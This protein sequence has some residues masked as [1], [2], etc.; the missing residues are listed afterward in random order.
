[1]RD[2]VWCQCH[3]LPGRP[4]RA[5]THAVS[6]HPHDLN[7]L[8]AVYREVDA[9]L[10]GW[11]CE[12]STDCCHFGRTGRE[13][14]LWPN[15]WA[16]LERALRARPVARTRRLPVVDEGRC[17]LLDDRGR[18]AAY[19]ERPFG[20]RTYFCA[21]AVGPARRPPRVELGALARRV[22]ALAE[23]ADPLARPRSLTRWLDGRKY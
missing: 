11:S 7:A 3:D 15:E 8:A 18:C 21:R 20:C 16:M 22:V 4:S 1:R 10:D 17:P 13:P 9:L 12:L 19:S 6:A 2:R 23:A 14:Q 5:R